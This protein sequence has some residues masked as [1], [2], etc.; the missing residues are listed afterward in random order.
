MNI[1]TNLF[2]DYVKFVDDTTKQNSLYFKIFIFLF[3]INIYLFLFFLF[4]KY[5]KAEQFFCT[6]NITDG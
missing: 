1:K 5:L 4:I 3:A 6:T 2:E